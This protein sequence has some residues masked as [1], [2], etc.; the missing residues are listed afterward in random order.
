MVSQ[1]ITQI[2]DYW[3]TLLIKITLFSNNVNDI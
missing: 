1:Q 3:N 2:K